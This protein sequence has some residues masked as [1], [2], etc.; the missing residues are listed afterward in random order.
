MVLPFSIDLQPGEPAYEQILSAIRKALFTGQLRDG[1]AFPSV[2]TLSQELRVSPTTAHKVV[3]L[4]KT[5]NLLAS[6]PGIGMVVTSARLPSTE[7]KR[8]MISESARKLAAEG[9]E[10]ALELNDVTDEL[11]NQWNQM[12]EE[13]S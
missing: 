2:R 6:R 3:S 1:D 10:L 12:E 7:E 11:K 8:G 4:L 5:E 9:K 13:S